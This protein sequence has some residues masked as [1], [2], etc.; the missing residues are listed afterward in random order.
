MLRMGIV[1]ING[2]RSDVNKIKL[3]LLKNLL[4]VLLICLTGCGSSKVEKVH[5]EI[6]I[7]MS[8]SEVM[9]VL[10]RYEGRHQYLIKLC[11]KDNICEDKMYKPVDF[12]T[13]TKGITDKKHDYSR[14]EAKIIVLFVGPGYLK[15]DF[16]VLLNADNKVSLKTPVKRWD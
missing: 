4:P 15:N 6:A 2:E 1:P 16:E 7:G 5:R 3:I 9:G 12:V 11:R 8:V 10:S 13:T 14:Y